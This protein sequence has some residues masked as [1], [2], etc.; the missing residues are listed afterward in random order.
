MPSIETG[1]D[2]SLT[3][4]RDFV[5][6]RGKKVKIVL[7]DSPEPLI[8]L[9]GEVGDGRV[10]IEVDEEDQAVSLDLIKKQKR[11]LEFSFLIF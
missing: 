10:L 3:S 7:L 5:R 6:Y 8:G 1:L 9:I 4:E 2:W 11:V